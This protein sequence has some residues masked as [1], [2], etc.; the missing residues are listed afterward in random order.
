MNVRTEKLHEYRRTRSEVAT[1]ID[2]WLKAEDERPLETPATE[3]ELAALDALRGQLTELDGRIGRLETALAD[4]AAKQGDPEDDPDNDD[5]S[6][7]E[8]DDKRLQ[9]IL[10]R[11]P[12]A[13]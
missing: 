1:K 6:N 8:D 13:V 11:N 4:D 10:G 5:E 3:E 12:S 9:R 2:A 7:R